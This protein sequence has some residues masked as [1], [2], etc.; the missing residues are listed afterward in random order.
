MPNVAYFITKR[1][2]GTSL[3]VFVLEQ[4]FLLKLNIKDLNDYNVLNFTFIVFI[5]YNVKK[6]NELAIEKRISIINISIM[7]ILFL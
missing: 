4:F 3:G 2:L 7:I 6:L 1:F 5:D